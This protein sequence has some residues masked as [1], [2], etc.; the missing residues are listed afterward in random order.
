MN[1][2]HVND[3]IDNAFFGDM[4][5]TSQEFVT[6]LRWA[7]QKPES[8][9]QLQRDLSGLS[10]SPGVVQQTVHQMQVVARAVHLAPN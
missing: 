2:Q 10:I 4:N 5:A 8:W 9:G 3:Q 6:S 1:V 7:A